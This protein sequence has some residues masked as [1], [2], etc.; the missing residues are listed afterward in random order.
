VLSTTPSDGVLRYDEGVFIGY[1]A[2]ERAGITPR[3]SFGHG[4]GYTT[5]EYEEITADQRAVTVT[6]RNT[7]ARAGREFVQ[8]YAGAAGADTAERPRRWLAGF[9]VVDAGPGEA[10]AV[11][12]DLPV[13]AFQIWADGA[14]DGGWETL[15]GDYVIEAA[16]SRADVRLIATV[17]VG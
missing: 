14:A 16:R 5:W 11:T 12:I 7:G 4:H 6:V 8:I 17:H 13:R 9:A 2:Y 3:Y 1:R 10:H 15:S